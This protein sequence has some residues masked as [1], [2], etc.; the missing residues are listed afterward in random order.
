M[1]D[2]V[3]ANLFAYT[4]PGVNYPEFISVNKVG[5]EVEFLVRTAAWGDGTCGSVSS[6]RLNAK[7]VA[8]LSEALRKT[9]ETQ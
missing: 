9:Q 2:N 5:D 8:E 1:P 4:S 7:Q 3:V 6:I